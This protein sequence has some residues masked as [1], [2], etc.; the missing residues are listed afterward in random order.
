MHETY[1]R[2]KIYCFVLWP[3][4]L[5]E[6][7]DRQ[8][9]EMLQITPNWIGTLNSQKLLYIPGTFPRSPNFG[10]CRSM[11]SCFRDTKSSKIGNAPKWPQ[12]ELEHLTVKTTLYTLNTCPWGP[13]FGLFHSMTGHFEIQLG[14]RKSEM[15]RMTP[16]WIWTLNSQKYSICTEY[17][18][19]RPKF[20]L[21]CSTTSRF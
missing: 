9:S 21:F 16:K 7:Q 15:H 19:Q 13:N 11:T 1:L 14:H 6:T 4:Q 12:T 10:P 20:G 8:K 5:F 18:C 2:F 3:L 17:L